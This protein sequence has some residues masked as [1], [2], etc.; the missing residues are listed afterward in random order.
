MSSRAQIICTIGPASGSSEVLRG[1]I[2]HHMDI[3]RLNFSHG[4]H[5][6]QG[7]YI[8]KI[9]EISLELGIKVLIMQ[10]LSGPRMKTKSGH[11]LDESATSVITEK[12]KKDLIFG[13][14]NGIDS[15]ALSYVKLASDITELREL[16]VKNGRVVKIV[17]KIERRE[18]VENLEKIIEVAD[19]VMVAR[20]DLGNEYPLEEVPF[21]QS[22][23]IKA[24]KKAGKPVFVATQMMLSMTESPTPTRAEVTDVESAILEGA[25]GVMLSEETATGKYPVES[26]AMMEK[27]VSYTESQSEI[28]TQAP[29]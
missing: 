11:A 20:G 5:D 7:E 12:D 24:C 15:V 21:V 29:I 25:D 3:A 8:K 4:N 27:I 26:V 19:A 17:A 23:I 6:E 18:A 16:M 1:L 2:E 13:M 9:K 22:K 10:D 28:V 14:E